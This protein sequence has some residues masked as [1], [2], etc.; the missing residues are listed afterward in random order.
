ML[1]LTLYWIDTHRW[2]IFA[3]FSCLLLANIT[4]P[5]G[6]SESG[7]DVIAILVMSTILLISAEV[8]LPTV[9]LLIAAFQ[10]L[11]EV[12]TPKG[13]SQSFMSDSV[14]FIMGSLMLAV[15]IVHQ[16]LDRRLAFWI[17]RL[18][19]GNINR[20]STGFILVCALMSAFIG[21]HTVAAIMLPVAIT[22]VNNIDQ[23]QKKVR[24]ISLMLML[25]I[26]YGCAVA[27]IG[28]PS[29]GARNAVMLDYWSRLYDIK[30]SYLEWMKYAFPMILIQIPIVA[31]IL[32]LTFK[33]EN[34]NISG[35]LDK[36]RETVIA[37]GKMG[38]A[39]WL[40]ISIFL[41][42][43]LLWVTSSDT[44]GL[45][46]PAFIGAALFLI[47]GLVKWE[48]LNSGVNWGVVLLYASAISLGVAMQKTGAASW[49]ANLIFD[50][51]TTIN[52]GG[53]FVLLLIIAITT[54][55]VANIMSH[56]PAV[57][58]LGPIF[59]E[60]AVITDTSLISAGFVIAIASSFTF[61][62]VIGSPANSII[63]ASNFVRPKDFLKAGWKMSI[64]S[65]IVLSLF[66]AAYW[67]LLS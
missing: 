19:K 9:P 22:I 18:A 45:G 36:L 24:N 5:Q 60:L 37:K 51:F 48:D 16:K 66:S 34:R 2:F 4:P 57:A 21:E 41:L 62:T 35:A 64:V 27:S 1:R 50:G 39:D 65:I 30:I 40:T 56:G 33:P 17:L 25:S 44:L 63:Y 7:M 20:L 53:G 31:I 54:M 28:T 61:M 15:A 47:T 11:F 55:L 8:P 3:I 6:L 58:I 52:L 59:L 29:G 26:A 42:T 46:I 23:D 14:F 32:R 43:L 13:V 10:V 49:V 38:Y 67:S 12:N